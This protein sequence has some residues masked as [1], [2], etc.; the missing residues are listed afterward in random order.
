MIKDVFAAKF[1]KCTLLK[2]AMCSVQKLKSPQVFC[3]ESIAV[4]TGREGKRCDEVVLCDV[5]GATGVYCVENKEGN[6]K[7]LRVSRVRRQLQGGADIVGA[8]LGGGEVVRFLPVLVSENDLP[9]SVRREFRL[10][11]NEVK[12]HNSEQGKLIRILKKGD[13]L[14]KLQK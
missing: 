7:N 2:P 11:D 5:R 4:Q 13:D 1:G 6:S 9:D 8:E 12:M 3:A 10:R 14:P